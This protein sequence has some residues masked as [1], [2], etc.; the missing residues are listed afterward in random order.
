MNLKQ[1]LRNNDL[2]PRDPER[3]DFEDW[4]E[5]IGERIEN[6][7]LTEGEA[8]YI[9]LNEHYIGLSGCS[10]IEN[11]I[12]LTECIDEECI[13]PGD[14]NNMLLALLKA[15]T[16]EEKLEALENFT[17][18]IKDKI[19]VLAGDAANEEC[20]ARIQQAKRGQG[21]FSNEP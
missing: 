8:D 6:D 15:K 9:S 5:E 14:L 19:N 7:L 20:Y 12:T 3:D 16:Q 17:D 4:E 11:V 2:D 13:D 18:A 21:E 1:R 10:Y